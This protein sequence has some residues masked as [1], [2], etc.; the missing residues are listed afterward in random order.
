MQL[1][2][3]LSGHVAQRRGCRSE[4]RRIHLLTTV[5]HER[6]SLFADWRCA[7][8]AAACLA[9]A[10]TWQGARVLCWVLMP[11]HWQ[12]LLQLQGGASLANLMRTAKGRAARDV[13]RA[14]G[15]G[16]TVWME[17]FHDRALRRDEDLRGTARHI[18]GNP[19]RAGLVGHVGQYPYWDAVW[20]QAT[21][22][23]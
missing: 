9:S 5:T 7:R 6:T 3:P 12:G 11:D 15:R 18:V 19:L 22:R 23:S 16:G 21:L 14:R 1:I 2:D 17:G 10:G 20:L 4:P 13:N 8:A